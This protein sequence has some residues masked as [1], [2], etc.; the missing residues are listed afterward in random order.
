[1]S[2]YNNSVRNSEFETYHVWSLERL[3]MLTVL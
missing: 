1:M 3:D 2:V